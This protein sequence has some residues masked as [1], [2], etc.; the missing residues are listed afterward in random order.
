MR[1]TKDHRVMGWALA[2]QHRERG[3]CSVLRCCCVHA[4]TPSEGAFNGGLHS[5]TSCIVTHEA[6]VSHKISRISRCGH[7][8]TQQP[9]WSR[10]CTLTDPHVRHPQANTPS[11]GMGGPGQTS[12]NQ[13][14]CKHGLRKRH[15]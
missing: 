2:A 5:L 13:G 6:R 7:E 12:E 15:A 8:V 1:P 11:L 9:H 4:P 3:R 14:P 10:Q